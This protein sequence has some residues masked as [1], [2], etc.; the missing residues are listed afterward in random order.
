MLDCGV[1]NLYL[2]PFNSNFRTGLLSEILSENLVQPVGLHL[3]PVAN[4]SGATDQFPT[5]WATGTKTSFLQR[6]S[7]CSC[8]RLGSFPTGRESPFCRKS[9]FEPYLDFACSRTALWTSNALREQTKEITC[10]GK[11]FSFLKMLYSSLLR[12]HMFLTHFGDTHSML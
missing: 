3:L 1:K 6:F 10:L 8:Y 5:G 4:W 11:T 12:T 2:G 9:C 7:D